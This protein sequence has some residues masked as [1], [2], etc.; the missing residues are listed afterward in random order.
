MIKTRRAILRSVPKT[1]GGKMQKRP[2]RRLSRK[3]YMKLYEWLKVRLET[4]K[5]LSA[6]AVAKLA[7]ND[8]GFEI[9]PSSVI[10]VCDD[11]GWKIKKTKVDRVKRNADLVALATFIISIA[12]TYDIEVPDEV[13]AIVV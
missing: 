4:L 13:K 2:M 12:E 6:N 7:E 3:Q 11:W 9:A 10:T 8:L 5:N 1:K